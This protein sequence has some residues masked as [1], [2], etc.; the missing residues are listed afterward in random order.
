M[1]PIELKPEAIGALMSV[2]K[3]DIGG[4]PIPEL[5]FYFGAWNGDSQDTISLLV[6]CGCYAPRVGNNAL[7][8]FGWKDADS[9]VSPELLRD[10][11][12]IFVEVWEPDRAVVFTGAELRNA[13][14]KLPW[15]VKNLFA[16]KKP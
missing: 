3:K 14:G 7:L 12:D 9:C 6:H 4:A 16:Y 1:Q 15:E 13:P 11:L 10:L 2:N 8:S 5:G